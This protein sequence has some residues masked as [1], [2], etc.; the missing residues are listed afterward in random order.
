MQ[1]SLLCLTFPEIKHHPS[2]ELD[3]NSIEASKHTNK[4]K[5]LIG[6][7][8]IARKRSTKQYVF[9]SLDED[10]KDTI[11]PS[12]MRCTTLWCSNPSVRIAYISPLKSRFGR[13]CAKSEAS[14]A[15]NMI[16]CHH[17]FTTPASFCFE[18]QV[19]IIS[20]IFH[21]L[22]RFLQNYF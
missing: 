11:L 19:F 13:R 14:R 16:L 8:V 22:V 2:N 21:M 5:T 3:E 18:L 9:Y 20:R 15:W 6:G 7:F 12:I 4:L 1:T 10:Y 17:F